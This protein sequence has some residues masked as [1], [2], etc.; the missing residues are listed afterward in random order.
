VFNI[1]D[2][3]M[4]IPRKLT[5]LYGQGFF[6]VSNDGLFTQ[7]IVF[8]YY[9]PEHYYLSILENEDK[10]EEEMQR[11]VDN[12]QSFLNEEEILINGIQTQPTV[13]AVNLEHRG[14]PENPVIT[15]IIHFKGTLKYGTN[16][17]ENHYEP[18]VLDYDYTAYWV[19]PHNM[20]IIKVEPEYNVEILGNNILIVSGHKG[21]RVEGYERITFKYKRLIERKK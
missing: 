20:K 16:I 1:V 8:D 13:I 6:T 10:Y 14:T 2:E 9:D 4:R 21:E 18:E 15:F 3:K 11:F 17:F 5:P 19:F 7:I 12:M